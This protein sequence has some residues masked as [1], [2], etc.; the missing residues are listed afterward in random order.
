MF[1]LHTPKSDIEASHFCKDLWLHPSTGHEWNIPKIP[2][3]AVSGSLNRWYIYICIANWVIICY[4]PPIK[5]TRKLHW[6]QQQKTT[7]TP[8]LFLFMCP[9]FLFVFFRLPFLDLFSGYMMLYVSNEKI[10]S[11][12]LFR[13]FGG[14]C[15][16]QSCGDYNALEGSLLNHRDSMESKA[17]FFSWLIKVLGGPIPIFTPRFV[18]QPAKPQKGRCILGN[19]MMVGGCN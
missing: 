9:C 16:V 12:R 3:I 1:S 13:G 8:K 17:V 11:K 15:T 5:G 10:G 7:G 6:Y 19:P 18:D 14:D 2:S 4:L